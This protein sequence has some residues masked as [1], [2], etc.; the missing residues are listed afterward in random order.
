ME[1]RAG[2]KHTVAAGI[3]HTVDASNTQRAHQT[4]GGGIKHTVA[5]SNTQCHWS[6]K[7]TVIASNTQW[8]SLHCSASIHVRSSTLLS[9]SS[10]A[11]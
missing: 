5:A 1:Q 9:L 4:H 10:A 2:I 6:I 7:H 3:K 8:Q 11:C